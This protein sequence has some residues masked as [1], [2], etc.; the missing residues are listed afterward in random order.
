MKFFAATN[1]SIFGTHPDQDP[2]PTV[3]LLESLPLQARSNYKNLVGSV[4]LAQVCAL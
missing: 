2:N 4:A 1:C 3:F